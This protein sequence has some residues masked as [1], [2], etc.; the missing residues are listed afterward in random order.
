M[1]RSTVRQLRQV[2][3]HRPQPRWLRVSQYQGS[4]VKLRPTLH[5]RC[6]TENKPANCCN[7]RA[8]HLHRLFCA[9]RR[10]VFRCHTTH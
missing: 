9:C 8:C 7:L 6:A 2:V 5:Q 10:P 4:Y 1:Q 3:P